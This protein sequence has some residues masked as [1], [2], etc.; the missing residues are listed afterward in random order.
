MRETEGFDQ[1]FSVVCGGQDKGQWPQ[2]VNW[3][4]DGRSHKTDMQKYL[5]GIFSR[6][7]DEFSFKNVAKSF[8]YFYF[9]DMHHIKYKLFSLLFSTYTC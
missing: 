1:P 2:I 8:P 3:L 4:V 5:S 9:S 6:Y 7:M